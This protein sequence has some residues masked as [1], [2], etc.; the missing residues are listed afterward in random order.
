MRVLGFEGKEFEE[1]LV[2]DVVQ[3]YGVHLA[4]STTDLGEEVSGKETGQ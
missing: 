2:G 4:V 3:S 1:R